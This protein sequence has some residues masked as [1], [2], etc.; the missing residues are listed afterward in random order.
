MSAR[1]NRAALRAVSHCS[2][3][4][5]LSLSIGQAARS[6]VPPNMIGGVRPPWIKA[7]AAVYWTEQESGCGTVFVK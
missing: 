1:V 3:C 6:E 5:L 7:P 2:L 4:T